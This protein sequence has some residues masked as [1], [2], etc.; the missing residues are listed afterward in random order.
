MRGHSAT[1]ARV[2][3]DAPNGECSMYRAP[4]PPGTKGIPT[5]SNEYCGDGRRHLMIAVSVS[6]N[7]ADGFHL[8]AIKEANYRD[9]QR[10]RARLRS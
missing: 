5:Y 3:G 10:A 7:P 9:W 8:Y 4:G 6:E 1:Y 2:L